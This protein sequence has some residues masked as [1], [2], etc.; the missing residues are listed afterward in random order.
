MGQDLNTQKEPHTNI[1]ITKNLFEFLYIIGKGGFGK[2]W[3][4]RFKKTQNKYALKEMSKVK[5]IDRK[6]EKSI[7]N[8]KDFLS[9]L[10]H[11]FLVNMICSFQDL[12]NLYLVMDLFQGGDLR[13]HLCLRKKFTEL[14]TKFFISC[15]LL[16]LQYIHSKNIIHRDI[17]PEN[18]V[19]DSNGYLALT[20]FGV[21]SRKTRDNSNETSGTPGYM[22]PEVLC[23]QNHSFPVDFFA[24]GIMAYEFMTGKRPY[25]GRNRKEIK[26]AVFSK[27]AHVHRRDAFVFGWSV[28]SCDFINRMIVRKPSKRLG[29]NGI[30][31]VMGH[32]WFDGIK[33]DDIEMRKMIAPFIPKNGDNFDRRYCEKVDKIDTATNERYLFY[34]GKEKYKEIFI[35]YTFVREDLIPQNYFE[36][37]KRRNL[38]SNGTFSNRES[39]LSTKSSYINNNLKSND[40]NYHS[41]PIMNYVTARKNEL[42]NNKSKSI[43]NIPN[44]S[45]YDIISYENQ[46]K[47]SKDNIIYSRPHNLHHSKSLCYNNSSKNILSNNS[48]NNINININNNNSNLNENNSKLQSPI[49]SYSRPVSKISNYN[50]SSNFS[51]NYK[52]I[53]K[54]AIYSYNNILLQKNIYDKNFSI[55]STRN[56]N[57]SYNENKIEIPTTR[58]S[59]LNKE[60]RNN[61][62]ILLK[63]ASVKLFQNYS[64]Y[65]RNTKEQN[66][67][68]NTSRIGSTGHINFDINIGKE[69]PYSGVP[70]Y[71]KINGVSPH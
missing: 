48:N 66:S 62:P 55:N 56:K 7:K 19:L 35:N 60:K 71:R 61:I 37:G 64:S 33:W 32:K 50:A 3:K 45:K 63:N 30:F 23:A 51:D 15:L 12:D 46:E 52:N 68:K 10:N 38:Y 54:K 67:F 49:Y 40:I 9:Q 41:I 42:N 8:E 29:Y 58:Y 59:R 14:E 53:I 44:S 2:V 69:R 24:I 11:P 6:S 36:E 22:A 17:K 20:D 1:Q 4:V 27:Q 21:A 34:K 18:L 57:S 26:E 39:D 70:S 65:L 43:N 16:S 28:D 25:L 47:A 31:E 5:I 13:Y